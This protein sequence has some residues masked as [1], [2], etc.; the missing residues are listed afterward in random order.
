VNLLKPI[1]LEIQVVGPFGASYSCRI[2]LKSKV[3]TNLT[4]ASLSQGITFGLTFV[5]ISYTNLASASL[6]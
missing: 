4:S 5:G 1:I 2:V 6:S 3:Y